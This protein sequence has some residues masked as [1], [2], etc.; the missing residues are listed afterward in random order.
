[1]QE[2]LLKLKNDAS[3]LIIAS[4]DEKELIEIKLDFLGRN[5]KLTQL[6]KGIKNVPAE[7]RAEVGR[8]ANE[9]LTSV[10]EL[11]NLRLSQI[12]GAKAEF[13]KREALDITLP[14]IRPK[15]GHLHLISQAIDEISEIFSHIGFTRVRYPEVEWDWYAYGALNFPENHPARDEVE[16]FFIDNDVDPKM[17]PMIL[18]PHTS[19]GQVREMEKSKLPIKMLNIAKVYRRQSDIS[20]S[21]IFHQFETLVVGENITIANLKGTLDYFVKSWFGEGRKTRL[22]PYDFRF[23]EPSFET[24]V[25]CGVCNGTGMVNGVKCRL[26]KE[27]WLEIGGAGIV[28]PNV[29]KAGGIDPNKYTG[30]ASGWGVERVLM[31]REG[32]ELDDLRILYSNNLDFLEQF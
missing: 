20:H 18:S 23:T 16:T 19:N 25:S 12:K 11:I 1:M 7:S 15:M 13:V 14:G 4:D 32:L 2:E 24:D 26:C 27:G 22:R 8:L 10:E 5:G 29:L 28:H 21:P 6:V 3:S 30:F 9:T 17:G 31:M